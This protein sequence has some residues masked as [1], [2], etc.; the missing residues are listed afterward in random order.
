M[1]GILEL[2]EAI[3]GLYNRLYRRGM[4]SQYSADNVSVS[5]GG[6]GSLTRAAASL[7]HVNLGHILPD[8]QAYEALRAIFKA[9]RAMPL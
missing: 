1:A 3:A 5:G 2:R 7:G 4:Q 8:Y 9:V 6:R